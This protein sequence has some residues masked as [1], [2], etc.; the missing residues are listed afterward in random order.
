L[1]TQKKGSKTGT[2]NIQL[3]LSPVSAGFP[4]PADDFLERN[5]DL[6]N[7]LIKHPSAT[8]FVRVQGDSMIESGIRSGDILI[9]DRA[10][11]KTDNKIAIALI[12]GEFIVKKIKKNGDK[13]W[14][15]P[16][17]PRYRP[18]EITADMNFEIW[19]VVTY[20]IHP[21]IHEQI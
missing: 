14:L 19:G 11:E 6:N 20:V 10:V 4:S 12:N 17:N 9:V 18:Q 15:M 1:E 13:L 2:G 7:Y 21:T 8:F 16:S 5:L 3:F